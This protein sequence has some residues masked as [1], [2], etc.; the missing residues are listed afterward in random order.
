MGGE[1]LCGALLQDHHVLHPGE[2][3]SSCL[4]SQ[5]ISRPIFFIPLTLLTF[6]FCNSHLFYVILLPCQSQHSHLVIQQLLGHL[7]ANSKNSARVRAGI[8]EVLL[9]AAAIAASGSVGALHVCTHMGGALKDNTKV[10]PSIVL[11]CFQV[12]QCWRCS[13]LCLGS[14]ASAWTTS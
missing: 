9:E 12:R 8:V 4:S 13:T 14:S 5:L 11:M 3:C 1:D 10:V 7:D 6:L 2:T